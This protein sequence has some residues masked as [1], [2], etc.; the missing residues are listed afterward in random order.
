MHLRHHSQA[1]AW[2]SLARPTRRPAARAH[3]SSSCSPV[4]VC[5]LAHLVDCFLRFRAGR[6]ARAVQRV[7][8]PRAG[9]LQRVARRRTGGLQPAMRLRPWGSPSIC[10]RVSRWQGWASFRTSR[11]LRSTHCCPTPRPTL[12][13]FVSGR[14]RVSTHTRPPAPPPLPVA[15]FVLPPRLRPATR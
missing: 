5:T 12:A 4:S 9:E 7:A 15:F 14:W 6:Q 1:R 10:A 8:R 2:R 11:L 3:T 13:I